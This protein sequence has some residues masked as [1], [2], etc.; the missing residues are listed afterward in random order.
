MLQPKRNLLSTA[1][2]SAIMLAAPQAFSQD[3][4]AQ[5]GNEAATE[6]DRVVVTGIRRGIENAIDT[7]KSSTSI[8]EAIS[9]EDI[10]KLP[11]LSI[12]ESLA[13]LPGLT[14]QR[15]A[16]RASTIQIR[17]LADDFS[18]ATLN[19]REQVSVGHNRGVEF[20]Q[21]P[22]ELLSQVVV[23]K[24][25]DASLV[26]QGLAGTVDLQ[27]VRPLSF[28]E[29]VVA[30]NLRGERNSLGELNDG[31]SD[32]G[33]RVSASYI[34]Q[35]MD[36]R[37]GLAIGFARLD[38]PG[39]ANRWESWGYPD[40]NGGSPGNRL[41]GGAKTQVSSVDNV[42]DGLMAVLEFKPNDSWHSILDLYYSRFDKSET[43]RFIES[44]LAWSGATLT[45]PVV[46]NGMVVSGTFTGVRPVVRNDVNTQ[47]D[48]VFA[49]GWNNAFEIGDLWTL[50]ADLSHSR[51]KREEMLL[52]TYVGL[53]HHTGP[54]TDTVDFTMDRDTG[55]ARFRH[56]QDYTDPANLVFTDPAGWGQAGFVKFPAVE[57]ELSSVRLDAERL[58]D[59]SIFSSVEFG[60]NYADR[61]KQRFS[62]VEGF[63]RVPGGELEMAIPADILQSNA[64][65]SFAGI[66]GMLGYDAVRA[67]ELLAFDEHSHPDIRNKNWVVNEKMA[68]AYA[69]WNLNAELGTVPMRG[70]IGVQFVRTEQDSTGYA[71]GFDDADAPTLMSGGAQYTEVLPSMN[72]A[73]ELPADQ[74]LRFGLGRQMA[75]PRMDKMRANHNYWVQ[76]ASD[77]L[78][79]TDPETG[80]PIPQ[81]RGSGGN[82]QLEPWMATAVDLSYEKYF[83]GRGY[84]SLAA[85]HKDLHSWI[86]D[87][88]RPYDFAGYGTG[89]LPPISIPPTT[90]GYFTEPVNV[91]GG[92]IYGFEAAVSVPMDLLWAPL[93]GFGVQASFTS[94][95]SSVQPEGTYSI[96]LPGLSR[97]VS[98]LTVYYERHGFSARV[99]Q[100]KR[101]DFL[102]EVQGFG[103]D[104]NERYIRGEEI[105]DL[106]LGYAFAEGGAL[107]GLSV[108]LQVNNLNN[109]PYREYYPEFDNLPRFF[110]EYGRQ[111]L[112]G[113]NYRF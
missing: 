9:A 100:R 94:N 40:D 101:S 70:N 32:T 67:M 79:E 98:N 58:F 77:D 110:S 31:Y 2:A 73:F 111:V 88:T 86:W 112:L 45:N 27:T 30:L 90:I 16:G 10:G 97:N 12:A 71:V 21:Y 55:L 11:D 108:L 50:R 47:D 28:P 29:R 89:E 85:F 51:A 23:Y 91:R 102:G 106:Q 22:S 75:R 3:T 61:S 48:R 82:P 64:D 17:G 4:T 53:G 95:R 14:A 63:L 33:Y 54:R 66:P 44:P 36:G 20:D 7:K 25:P 15:V 69:Q 49:A 68:T 103:G 83:G 46:E 60:L 93:E 104:R 26:G 80:L 113:V 59:T 76:L 42:R 8:V 18:T 105:V 52:E 43:L 92:Q 87:Q 107:Q 13:R 81:W 1:L 38:S 74:L 34:D 99:S 41:I 57:D 19:G 72:L 56:V 78:T 35:F 39:Q 37:F 5:A 6:L 109:E 96:S 62:G 84:V 24:T 65:L